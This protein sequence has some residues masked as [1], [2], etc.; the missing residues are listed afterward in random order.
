MCGIVALVS[1]GPVADRLVEGLQRLEYRGYDSAGVATLV[2]GMLER[3]RA[4]GKLNELRQ[5]LQLNPLNGS[6]GIAHTRWATHGQA[7]A[8]NAHPHMTDKVAVVHNGIIEN[9]AELRE[10]LRAAGCEFESETDTEIISH[11]TTQQL[12]QGKTPLQAVEV[13]LKRLEGAFALAFIFQN[14]DNLV[15]AARQGSPLVIGFG[16]GEA[17]VG[18]DALVLAPWMNKICYLQDGDYATISINATTVYDKDGKMVERPIRQTHL[19]ADA[20][21]K[22]EF[23]H[24]MLKEIHEQPQVVQATQS[25]LLQNQHEID[26]SKVDKLSIVACGTSYYAGLVAKY[27]FEAIARMNVEV[28]IASEYRYRLPVLD[29]KDLLFVISQSGETIDTYSAMRMAQ[30]SGCR[31]AAIVNVPESSIAREADHVF[32]S[33]AGPEIGVASTKAFTTQLVVLAYLA[34]DAGR[35]RG[36]LTDAQFKYYVDQLAQLPEFMHAL[37]EDDTSIQELA[38]KLSAANYAIYLGR[39]SNFPIALEG[40]LKLKEITYIFSQAYP[41]GELKHG[42]I[43]LIDENVPVVVVCPYDK[44]FAKTASNVQEVL[45]RGGMVYCLTDT[46][47]AEEFAKLDNQEQLE[48]FTM[49]VSDPFLNPILYAIPV[50]LLAYHTALL[51]GTDVDQPRNLAKSVTVE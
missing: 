7:T 13:V 33:H 44:W 28:D 1:E 38:K 37:L 23:R 11:L 41:A 25:Y 29:S 24:F 27:W 21:S 12:Q 20:T 14:Y 48:I 31:T 42:P 47:G 32:F 3:R 17:A 22:G 50:Q 2:N 19:N 9:H 5:V 51:K 15:I 43:A 39:G 40:S 6:V 49:P 16:D 36:T 4:K 8:A 26:W 45:A 18:S 34:L 10:E 30:D 46:K 35:A